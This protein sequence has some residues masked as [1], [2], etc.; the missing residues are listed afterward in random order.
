MTA[1]IIQDG[2]EGKKAHE[3]A[4]DY[5]SKKIKFRF[6]HADTSG[7]MIFDVAVT[8]GVI[9]VTLNTRH[10]VHSRL[11][12][13]LRDNESPENQYAKEVLSLVAAWAR[14]EDEAPSEKARLAIEDVRLNWGRMA[15]DFFEVED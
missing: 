10:P 13:A 15:M 12:E 14:M 5:V 2:V 7:Q 1:E 11:F 6:K 8:G 4:V 9:L 3:I